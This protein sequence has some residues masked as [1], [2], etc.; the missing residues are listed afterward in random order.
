MSSPSKEILYSF[1]IPVYNTGELLYETLD[2][3]S[4]QTFDLSLIE[5]I[6]INDCSTDGKTND[7]INELKS[8][9]QFNNMPLHVILN[10]ANKWLAETRNIGVRQAKGK[11]L[12]CLDSDDTIEPDFL[13]LANLTFAAYPNASWVYPSVRKFGYKNKTDIAPDFSAKSLFLQNCQVAVSPVKRELWNELG[14]QKTFRLSNGVKLFEDWD[15]WQRAIG[16][17]CYGVPIKKVVFNYRQNITSLITRSEDEGNVS[18]LLAYRKNWKSVF[19]IKRAQNNFNKHNQKHASRTGFV[20]NQIKRLS[21]LILR[22]EPANVGV[23]DVLLYLFA[24]S[25][26]AQ[27]KTQSEY[28]FT[29]THKMAGFIQGFKLPTE[30]NLKLTLDNQQTVLCTHYWWHVGGAENVLYDYL[31]VLKSLDYKIVDVVVKGAN[32]A[33]TLKG[34][35]K[36]VS[37]EQYTLEEVAQ[38]PFPQLLA[39]WYIIKTERPKIIL[40]MSN[41]FLYLLSPLIQ[42]KFPNTKIYDLLH[43]EDFDD[44]GW[45]EAAYHFQNNINCRIVIS[46][47]WKEVLIQKY[48]EF[49]FKIKVIYN[50]INYK[51]FD[52]SKVTRNDLLSKLKINTDKKII[53]FIGRFQEQK[54]PDIFLKVVEKMQLNTDYHFVMAG[55][56][57]YLADMMPIMS[58]LNNLT[59]IG[60]TKNPENVLPMFDVAVF[61][62]KYEGYPLVGIEAAYVGLPIIASNIVGFREQIAN[63]KFGILYDVKNDEDDSDAIKY[64]LLNNY[65]EL[66][67]L[68]KN[69]SAFVNQ[70]HNPQQIT[71]DLINVFND[72]EAI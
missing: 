6:I 44:N 5:I 13:K 10:K 12:V 24:P 17:G 40:N 58:R 30:D 32:E 65:D 43:C 23:K 31:E 39:L 20:Y 22:R 62:S 70:F 45:F 37:D 21:K 3:I 4:K 41:P 33:K 57:E 68:G 54:R 9:G 18:T 25:K 35:F 26:F 14:G 50:K 1:I 59:Y 28:K 64:I 15:F 71:S 11:Y 51:A 52:N 66:L 19:G 63:G 49:P 8:L 29:K 27:L 46:E 67:Q 47:F 61:P 69:G 53:G 7:I 16:K 34:K 42:D 60:P 72:L 38:G 55:D 2:S 56:G 48:K 36:E